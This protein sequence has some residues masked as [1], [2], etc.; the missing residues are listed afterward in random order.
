M[1]VRTIKSVDDETWKIMRQISRD[2]KVKMGGLL[3]N[4]VNVYAKKGNSRISSIIPKKAILTE[5]EAE[6]MMKIIYKI[7]HERGFRI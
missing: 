3:K 1:K 5:K 4:M 2:E 7:R 6:D